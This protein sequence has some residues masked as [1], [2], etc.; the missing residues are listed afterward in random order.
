MSDCVDKTPECAENEAFFKN[1]IQSQ[2]NFK[3]TTLTNAER[4]KLSQF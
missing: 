1:Y 4:W 3:P 2:A